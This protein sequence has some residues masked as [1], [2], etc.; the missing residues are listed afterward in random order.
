MRVAAIYDVHGNLPALDAVLAELDAEGAADVVLVGGDVAAGPLPGA[1]LERLRGLGDRARF[2]RGNAD[3]ELVERFDGGPGGG[4]DVWERRADWAAG[5]LTRPQRDFLAA[6]PTTIALEVEGLG[7]TLFC[8]GSPRSDE[9]ILTRLT[10]DARLGEA[11]AEVAER[12]VVC[13]HTHVQ[14]D[15]RAGP[16]RVVNAG[17]VGMPYER[18]PGAYWALLG[19][20]VELRRTAYDLDAAAARFRAASFPEVDSFVEDL[21]HPTGPDEASEFFERLA[22]E[23]AGRS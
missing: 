13:G 21:L 11:L 5:E 15:R 17:S 10:D 22:A 6:L 16:A 18:E 9:E 4:A 7:R 3:R 12:V 8:H 14:F 19:P 2:L 23:R 1:T 20:D